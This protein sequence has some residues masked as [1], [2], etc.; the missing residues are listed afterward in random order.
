MPRR[1]SMDLIKSHLFSDDD[2]FQKLSKSDQQL[3]I[4]I[5]DCYTV[6]INN[7]TYT[8]VQMRDYL[9]H[10]YKIDQQKAY[11]IISK[12]TMVLGSVEIASKNWIK[13]VIKDIL[14]KAFLLAEKDQLKKAEIY[15]KIAQTWA[16]AFNT[17]SDDGEVLNA[18]EKL[19][20]DNVTII[21]N[22]SDIG[23]VLNGKERKDIQKMMK[24][25]DIPAD[26][27]DVEPIDIEEVHE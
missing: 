6:W 21:S 10:S 9:M 16:K 14:Q 19:H 25:Y 22:P 15:T 4:Q 5:R 17:A 13:F 12:T 2:D 11:S 24:K 23:I 8:N 26:I 18:K 3:L 27:I 1:N 7:P 20:I